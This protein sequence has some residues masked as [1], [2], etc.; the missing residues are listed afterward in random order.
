MVWL[1]KPCCNS[2]I[3]KQPSGYDLADSHVVLSIEGEIL[4]PRSLVGF[5]GDWDSPE[6]VGKMLWVCEN[7]HCSE[8]RDLCGHQSL[9]GLLETKRGCLSLQMFQLGFPPT[10]QTWGQELCR[11]HTIV[12]LALPSF[13]APRTC[14]WGICQSRNRRKG[15]GEARKMEKRR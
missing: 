11:L 7:A 12:S 10:P 6:T 1:K 15:R 8:D 14:S 5:Q 13:L 2:M 4:H 9:R 3:S